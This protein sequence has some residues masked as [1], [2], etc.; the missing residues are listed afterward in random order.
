MPDPH[1]VAKVRAGQLLE[2]FESL[3]R[4][5]RA[6]GAG[7]SEGGHRVGRPAEAPVV[8]VQSVVLQTSVDR[9]A[10]LDSQAGGRA[11]DSSGRDDFLHT[12]RVGGDALE[13][14][15]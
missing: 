6:T 10:G 12:M 1:A 3:L 5:M 7:V 11:A 8:L 9:V 15:S 14:R 2:E 4:A 13:A